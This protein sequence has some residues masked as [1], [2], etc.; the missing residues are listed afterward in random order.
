MYKTDNP[1]K[2]MIDLHHERKPYKPLS[3]SRS[4]SLCNSNIKNIQ[5]G[6][7][8]FFSLNKSNCIQW[9]LNVMYCKEKVMA[10]N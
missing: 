9:L 5:F 7:N 3:I 8:A 10:L 6:F 1:K 4:N 2:V